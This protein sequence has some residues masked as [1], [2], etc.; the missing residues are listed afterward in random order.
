LLQTKTEVP[1]DRAVTA[2]SKP[3][4]RLF[5][6]PNRVSFGLPLI[7]LSKSA[8]RTHFRQQ[9]NIA[10]YHLFAILSSK[11]CQFH[12]AE[13]KRDKASLDIFWLKDESLEDSANLPEPH[14]IAAEIVDD[15][16]AALDEFALIAADLKKS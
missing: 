16:Q 1:F 9:P 10:L 5:R 15:L 6:M 13:E 12:P 11:L 4:F 7:Q 2:W 8:Y 3:F 14:L